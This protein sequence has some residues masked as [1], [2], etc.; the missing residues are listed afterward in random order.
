M[1]IPDGMEVVMVGMGEGNVT[2]EVAGKVAANITEVVAVAG[3]EVDNTIV[4]DPVAG[5]AVEYVMGAV[6]V[7]GAAPGSRMD[8]GGPSS[9]F[10]PCPRS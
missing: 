1:P 4:E 8:W 5:M 7:D 10:R 3:T 6:L 9:V 2:A